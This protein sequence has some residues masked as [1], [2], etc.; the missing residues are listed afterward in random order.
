MYLKSAAQ[1]ALTIVLVASVCQ[2]QIF[3]VPGRLRLEWEVEQPRDGRP[4]VTGYIY[5]DFAF[6]ATAIQL[7]VEEMD[8]AGRPVRE[9]IGY[10]DD[11]V[12]PGLRTYFEVPL[13]KA[14]V[15]YRVTVLS[16]DWVGG[17]GI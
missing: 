11:D 2:A 8:N 4:T 5:N 16:V 1:V 14:G 9:T 15:T 12:P 17:G 10:V 3:G 13:P 7:L 6:W